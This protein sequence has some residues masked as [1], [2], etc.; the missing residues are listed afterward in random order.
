[1]ESGTCLGDNDCLA[2]RRCVDTACQ[3]PDCGALSAACPAG[4]WCDAFEPN[5][6]IYAAV[7]LTPGT[8]LVTLCRSEDDWFTLTHAPGDGLLALA[9]MLDPVVAGAQFELF[10]LENE[11]RRLV[12][13]AQQDTRTLR[14]AKDQ[15]P[16]TTHYLR[17]A[18]LVGGM[19]R[20]ELYV[21][22]VPGGYCTPDR[23]E[24]N[25]FR[26]E[27]V[28]MVPSATGQGDGPAITLCPGDEDWFKGTLAPGKTLD[29]TLLTTDGPGLALALY[30]GVNLTLRGLD[31]SLD[32]TKVLTTYDPI[33][34][35]VRVYRQDPTVGERATLLFRVRD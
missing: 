16:G 5:D 33:N 19:Q 12:M 7:P 25:D 27:A 2:P 28:T 20:V 13:G 3:E 6:S 35:E 23:W 24:P 34:F 9:T 4:P 1:M 17:L 21:E 15:M 8:H 18:S 22:L 32:A 30:G 14:L 10:T 26:Q 11:I 29:V 31:T